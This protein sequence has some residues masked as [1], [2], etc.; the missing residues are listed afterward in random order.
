MYNL[1][2]HA[3]QSM[4][5]ALVFISCSE[6]TD[7]GHTETVFSTTGHIDGEI[8]GLEPG[9]LESFL[10]Q[11]IQGIVK[12]LSSGEA[13]SVR[14]LETVNQSTVGGGAPGHPGSTER[15]E[16]PHA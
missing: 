16:V 8:P 9:T 12:A 7:D 5:H 14:R 13:A 3:H 4:H 15:S 11:T 10:E 6:T 2:I 1:N